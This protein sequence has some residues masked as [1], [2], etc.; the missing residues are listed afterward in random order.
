MDERGGRCLG[1]SDAQRVVLVRTFG[2][3]EKS[4]SWSEPDDGVVGKAL[5]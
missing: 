3:Q 4:C 1:I 2:Y 5:L